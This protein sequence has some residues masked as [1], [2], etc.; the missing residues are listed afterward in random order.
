MRAARAFGASLFAAALLLGGTAWTQQ[1]AP[2][3]FPLPG[4]SPLPAPPLAVN[5]SAP[6][7]LSPQPLFAP[8]WPSQMQIPAFL[9][10]PIAAPLPQLPSLPYWSPSRVLVLPHPAD[11]V[12]LKVLADIVQKNLLGGRACGLREMAPGI[13]VRL[14]CKSEQPVVPSRQV[15]T[16]EKM[17][18]LSQGKLHMSRAHA[19]PAPNQIEPPADGVDHRVEGLEGPVKDQGSVGNCTAFSLSTV[20]DNA[21]LRMHKNDVMSPA[22]IWSHYAFPELSRASSGNMNKAIAPLNVWPYSPRQACEM[23]KDPEE[24]CGQAYA[25]RTNSSLLDPI[26]QAQYLR[27][28][29]SG[30]YRVVGVDQI[31]TRPVNTDAIAAVL[32]T[33]ADVWGGMD[34]DSAAWKVSGANAVIPEYSGNEG[35]HAMALAGFR[36]TANGRQFLIHNSWGGTWGDHGF[37]WVSENMVRQHMHYAFKIRIADVN[38]NAPV[39]QTD[40]ECADN[41]LVDAGTGKCA[42]MCPKQTRS[43]NGKC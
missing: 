42:A 36:K 22:H 43:T 12:D 8:F 30:M 16:P 40:D 34:I 1:P 37:A 6:L 25:V 33:G 27:A 32:E 17:Q 11:L 35:G 29:A 13:F 28:E 39:S 3:P 5:P 19:A 7:P 31:T 20:M 18:M 38:G 26:L 24:Q 9:R 23:A 14:D 10:A 4:P 15:F 21:I 41:Q 2:P